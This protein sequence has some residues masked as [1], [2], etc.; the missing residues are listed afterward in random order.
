MKKNAH[1]SRGIAN[2]F[3]KLAKCAGRELTIRCN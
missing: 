2:I 1:D 3:I